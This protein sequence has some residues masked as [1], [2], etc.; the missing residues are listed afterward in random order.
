MRI[1]T[2]EKFDKSDNYRRSY[3]HFTT[4]L[5][6]KFSERKTRSGDCTHYRSFA[7]HMAQERRQYTHST[8][9]TEEPVSPTGD[10]ETITSTNTI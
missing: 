6:H 9:H 1:Y 7:S 4:Y 2:H 8:P 3:D 10:S 5:K